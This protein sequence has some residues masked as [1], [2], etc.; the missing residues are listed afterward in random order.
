MG[1]KTKFH[2]TNGGPSSEN[3]FGIPDTAKLGIQ[4]NPD[5]GCGIQILTKLIIPTHFQ[6][7]YFTFAFATK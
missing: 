6:G 7:D 4:M 2:F 3:W 5:F 1:R